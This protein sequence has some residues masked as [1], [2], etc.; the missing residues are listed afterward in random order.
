MTVARTLGDDHPTV[1]VRRARARD[2]AT[3]AGFNRAMA[4]ET[5]ALELV[6]HTVI[7]GVQA[8][9]SDP[10]RGFYFVAELEERPIGALMVTFD[11]SDWRNAEVWWIQ[12]VYVTPEH[13][14]RGALRALHDAVCQHA[15]ER[16]GVCG[17]RLC[18]EKHN[19]DAQ[20]AY[21]ALGLRWSDYRLFEQ[22]F[23]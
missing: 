5:E 15:H 12:S 20:N 18:V 17:L 7:A 4:R 16:G 8:V 21:R 13:R 22:E 6:P 2:A 14:G 11:W 10:A 9:L 1:R 3:L 23:P 19:R